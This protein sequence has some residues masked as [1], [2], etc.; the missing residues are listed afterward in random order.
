MATAISVPQ[1][2]GADLIERLASLAGQPEGVPEVALSAV[3]YGSMVSLIA[4][5]IIEPPPGDLQPD[6]AFEVVLTRHGRD[7]IDSCADLGTP[8][9]TTP[10]GLSSSPV[11]VP[12]SASDAALLDE[13]NMEIGAVATFQGPMPQFGDA[14]E[15]IGA[16]LDHFPRYRQKLVSPRIGRQRWVRDP[17]F[18]L[19]YHVRYAAIPPP[20]T[21]AELEKLVARIFS[22]C[23]DR[24]KPLWEVWLVAGLPAGRFAVISKAHVAVIDGVSGFELMTMLFDVTSK[25]VHALADLPWELEPPAEI[26]SPGA[27]FAASIKEDAARVAR[28]IP[29]GFA[30]AVD[31]PRAAAS[32]AQRALETVAKRAW[33]RLRPP[34]K[35]P[36]GTDFSPHRRTALVEA[37]MH[38]FNSV[39]VAFGATMDDVV[40]AVIAG[41]LRSWLVARDLPSEEYVLTAAVPVC[42][43]PA[44][45]GDGITSLL[46][47][48]PVDR[49]DP[50]ERLERSHAVLGALGVGIP[51]PWSSEAPSNRQPKIVAHISRM[52]A[53]RQQ[54]DLLIAN[55]PGPPLPLFF[56][57][58]RMESIYPIPPL[59]NDG[60]AALAVMA[61][62][63]RVH[64]SVVGDHRALEDLE[65]V[66]QGLTS[67]LRELVDLSVTSPRRLE[68]GA[69]G[70]DE[71]SVLES[72]TADAVA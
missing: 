62:D 35:S 18:N 44:L 30:A 15:Y 4:H 63:D 26:A 67:A 70:S 56:R 59:I 22:Q 23:L 20:G 8:S 55:V 33:Q 37:D 29:S 21:H 41:A 1:T 52:R 61:Y 12:I 71:D 66:A 40:V 24:T 16:R 14:L 2:L 31:D 13:E 11:G 49:A 51:E 46:A 72:P 48:L 54:S 58:R 57:Q 53:P 34:P 17:D 60:A 39:Q 7:I 68:T 45:L 10:P 32:K 5:G 19:D 25:P 36:L 42:D 38:D 47:P 69:A 27:L 43:Q 64:F 3:P 6:A 28:A 65:I 9:L 50:F